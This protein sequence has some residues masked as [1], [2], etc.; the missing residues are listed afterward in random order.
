MAERGTIEF[1]EIELLGLGDPLGMGWERGNWR[2][3]DGRGRRRP[4]RHLRPA[5]GDL[6][7]FCRR[8]RDY[9]K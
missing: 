6:C 1:C 9:L 7:L 3:G 2:W 4:R 5:L 8:L